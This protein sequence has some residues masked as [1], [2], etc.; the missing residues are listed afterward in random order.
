LLP[1]RKP[2][3]IV[4]VRAAPSVRAAVVAGTCAGRRFQVLT[5][6]GATTAAVRKIHRSKPDLVVLS[7]RCEGDDSLLL[8]Q[9]L[10][11]ENSAPRVILLGLTPLHLDVMSFVRAGVSGFV[12]A[13]ASLETFLGAV[14]SV[15]QGTQVLPPE[16]TH[17]LFAQLYL[18]ARRN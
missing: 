2:I 9:A 18:D 8:A 15:A 5:A 12:M 6:P 16:L 11:A 4:L 13:Q 17:A 14:C 7:L 3:S 1:V 10:H